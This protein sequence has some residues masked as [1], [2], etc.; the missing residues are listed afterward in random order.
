MLIR[1]SMRMLRINA[2]TYIYYS[3]LFAAFATNSRHSHQIILF[4][5]SKHFFNRRFAV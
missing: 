3:H 2:N 5:Y 1:K 4:N